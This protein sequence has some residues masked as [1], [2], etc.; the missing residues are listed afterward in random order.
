MFSRKKGEVKILPAKM[1][2]WLSHTLLSI[3]KLVQIFK[4]LNHANIKYGCALSLK[5]ESKTRLMDKYFYGSKDH[6][7]FREHSKTTSF[8]FLNICNSLLGQLGKKL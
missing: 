4:P 2:V 5:D 6:N 3:E 7:I 8:S 1:S